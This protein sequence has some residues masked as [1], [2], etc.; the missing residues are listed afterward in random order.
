MAESNQMSRASAR[1]GVAA[2]LF[3]TA[4]V[5]ATN[6]TLKDMSDPSFESGPLTHKAMPSPD[7]PSSSVLPAPVVT[8]NPLWAVSLSSLTA[9]RDRP[10]FSPSRRPPARVIAN[11]PIV[12]ER[13]APP[14]PPPEHPNLTLVGTVAREAE[15]EAVFLDQATSA[16]VRLRMG[17]AH[18]G[19]VL[20][21]VESRTAI[22]RKGEQTEALALL[23]P[24]LATMP[25]TP[26]G[27]VNG[28]L[29]TAG[30]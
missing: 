13:P 5:A 20:Q 23:R 8:G 25:R 29:P 2:I 18:N 21:S 24:T 30:C 3:Y 15:S 16:T 22:L 10:L 14:P 9:I 12:P 4:A 7:G 17:D 6:P 28:C 27:T 1:I 26:T 11:A 19:W